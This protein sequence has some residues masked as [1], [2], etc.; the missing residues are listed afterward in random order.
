VPDELRQLL[1]GRYRLRSVDR[2]EEYDDLTPEEK[3]AIVAALD[4]VEAESGISPE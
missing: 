4:E 1:P 3:A 2:I